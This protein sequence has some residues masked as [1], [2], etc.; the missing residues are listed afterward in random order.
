MEVLGWDF[1]LLLRN[2]KGPLPS[3]ARMGTV[4]HVQIAAIL[5]KRLTVNEIV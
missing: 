1:L 2:V 5:T 4:A 3:C